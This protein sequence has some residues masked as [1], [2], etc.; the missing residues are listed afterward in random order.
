MEKYENLGL[1]GE[2]SYGMV[3]KCRHKESGQLVAIK[4]FLESDDDK[5]V[6]KIAT[7]EIKMLKALRHENLVNLIEYFRRKKKLYLVF[8]F[9]D[10]TVLD[11]LE[12]YPNGLDEQQV[13]KITYQVLRAIDFCHHHNIIHR[14]IKPENILVS[15]LGVVKLCDFGFARTLAGPGEIYTDYV[16][17]R[18]YRAPELLVGDANYGKAVDLWAIGCLI[19]EML[20]GNPL[21]PGDSDIDQLYHITSWLGNLSQ[22]YKEIFMKNPI[23]VG[24]KLPEVNHVEPLERRLPTLSHHSISIV[25]E[26]LR[27]DASDRP[28]CSQLLS[29]TY[30]NHDNFAHRFLLELRTKINKEFGSNLLGSDPRKKQKVVNQLK[31]KQSKDQKQIMKDNKKSFAFGGS[32]AAPAAGEE[33]PKEKRRP[34]ESDSIKTTSTTKSYTKLPKDLSKQTSLKRSENVENISQVLGISQL[35][36]QNSKEVEVE[37]IEEEFEKEKLQQIQAYN[38]FSR[39]LVLPPAPKS[40][41]SVVSAD[42]RISPL[43][44]PEEKTKASPGSPNVQQVKAVKPTSKGLQGK[45]T[46]SY[47]QKKE[48]YSSIPKQHLILPQLSKGDDKHSKSKASK[49]HQIA[50]D[51]FPNQ[52]TGSNHR[53]FS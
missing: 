51:P 36:K 29:H 45:T 27:L 6:K 26:C 37:T 1:V 47:K 52:N 49:L 13:R 53:K 10:H 35:S 23:F 9:V 17:T 12:R 20:T 21:F 46:T 48:D 43:S 19:V 14:D 30:F 5:T 8:E 3:M 34:S 38:D 50:I 22:R 24:M 32:Y 44:A 33:E 7:R 18:W 11:D 28:T 31:A 25:K 16:A 40:K 2:G 39:T 42:E 41:T 4:K 15:K